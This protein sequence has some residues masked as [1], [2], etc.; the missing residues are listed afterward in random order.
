MI[1]LSIL[2]IWPRHFLEQLQAPTS[3]GQP[4]HC[5]TVIVRRECLQTSKDRRAVQN[6]LKDRR[7]VQNHLNSK[8]V[9]L[10]WKIHLIGIKFNYIIMQKF[11][12]NCHVWH[13]LCISFQC[14]TTVYLLVFH[15]LPCIVTV[16]TFLNQI[17]R[18]YS[19][20]TM[21][22]GEFIETVSFVGPCI[23]LL[24]SWWFEA[25]IALPSVMDGRKKP[26]LWINC[27][28]YVDLS[29]CCIGSCL[30]SN[31][32]KF[33][34]GICSAG[35]LS[36]GGLYSWSETNRQQFIRPSDDD[37]SQRCCRSEICNV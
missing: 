33:L 6:H 22:R 2:C 4:G 32:W 30:M 24:D 11:S 25:N 21:Q 18:V 5:S 37:R 3:I 14:T 12:A 35:S 13:E 20:R 17:D 27:T 10:E 19:F 26:V 1:A 9:W 31:F 15:L 23:V 8:Q 16:K 7:A 34:W 36:K 28:W 29:C